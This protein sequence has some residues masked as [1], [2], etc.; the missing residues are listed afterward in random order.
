MRALNIHEVNDVR[1]DPKEP[2]KAGDNDVVVKMKAVG[3]WFCS[4]QPCPAYPTCGQMTADA[5]FSLFKP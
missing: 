5:T 1:L 2:P 4:L 3:I